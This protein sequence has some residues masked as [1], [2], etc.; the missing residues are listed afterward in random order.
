MASS[1]SEGANKPEIITQTID[2]AEYVKDLK[3]H[4]RNASTSLRE[5][6]NS[7]ANYHRTGQNTLSERVNDQIERVSKEIIRGMMVFT[8]LN[9]QHINNDLGDPLFNQSSHPCAYALD[10]NCAYLG[11]DDI[12]YALCQYEP[13]RCSH[14]MTDY[15]RNLNYKDNNIETY[16]KEFRTFLR[17]LRIQS[18]IERGKTETNVRLL[19]FA[20]KGTLTSSPV[21]LS[22][23]HIDNLIKDDSYQHFVPKLKSL[24][25]EKVGSVGV[26]DLPISA[27]ISSASA[28]EKTATEPEKPSDGVDTGDQ[29]EDVQTGNT[30][31]Q[32]DKEEVFVPNTTDANEGEAVD[33]NKPPQSEPDDTKTGNAEDDQDNWSVNESEYDVLDDDIK[34][35]HD[36]K[37]FDAISVMYSVLSD[38]DR[39]YV[40]S[41]EKYTNHD[42][43]KRVVSSFDTKDHDFYRAFLMKNNTMIDPNYDE[44]ELNKD[45]KQIFDVLCP[46]WLEK[47]IA[48]YASDESVSLYNW[49][50]GREEFDK[51]P[52]PITALLKTLHPDFYPGINRPTARDILLLYDSLPEHYFRFLKKLLTKSGTIRACQTP[53]T[54]NLYKCTCLYCK[55]GVELTRRGFFLLGSEQ[56]RVKEVRAKRIPGQTKR[57]RKVAEV[58]SADE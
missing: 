24:G 54:G 50:E 43:W 14:P 32:P 31:P 37:I 5:F 8:F 25:L 26:I 55:K 27:K 51:N 23:E 18:I 38:E 52:R 11:M 47:K 20:D 39:L 30:D 49:V 16:N 36:D 12:I 6:F 21:K 4:A 9:A 41:D 15:L 57:K 40:S 7:L 10:M 29:M 1:S 42:I 2:E 13:G 53:K 28:S 35:K 19:E 46:I 3:Q 33:G 17:N 45:T 44:T 34:K 48:K 56:T 58:E 22:Q